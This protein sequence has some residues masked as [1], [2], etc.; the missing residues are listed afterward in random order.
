LGPI[1]ERV[2]QDYAGRIDIYKVDTEATPELSQIF[3]IRGIP[4]ILFAPMTGEP[5]MNSGL[6]PQEAFENAIADLF[7]IKK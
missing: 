7:G 2:A 4:A 6:I 3:G 1:L 5:A